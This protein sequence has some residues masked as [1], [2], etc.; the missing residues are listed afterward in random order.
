VLFSVC[1]QSRN[2]G[3]PPPSAVLAMLVAP[4]LR[5]E[6]F[7]RSSSQRKS[8]SGGRFWFFTFVSKMDAEAWIF[9]HAN[10]RN[11]KVSF[12][13]E[14]MEFLPSVSESQFPGQEQRPLDV[15][16]ARVRAWLLGCMHVAVAQQLSLSTE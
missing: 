15:L 1:P 3:P 2:L 11:N 6:A 10:E 13:L 7:A 14:A 5:G 8:G 12:F 9:R 16:R 4:A